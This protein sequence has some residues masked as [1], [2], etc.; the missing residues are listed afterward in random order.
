MLRNLNQV[1]SGQRICGTPKSGVLGSLIPATGESGA[2]Y[3]Y[4][5][6]T[7]PADNDKEIRGKI[8]RWPT[9]G[10]LFAFEDTSFTYDGLTDSFDYQLAVDGVEVG[11]PVTVTLLVGATTH[12]S[13]GSLVSGSAAVSGTSLRVRVHSSDGALIADFAQLVGSAA[14]SGSVIHAAIA[15]LSAGAAQIA[16]SANRVGISIHGASGDLISGAATLTASAS[17]SGS[18]VLSL[19]QDDINAIA[20]AVLAALNAT[21]IPVDLIKVKGQ[22]ITGLGTEASPWG[23]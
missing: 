19:T 21:A 22:T 4:N 20:A 3:A 15:G 17:R 5:D 9:L 7:L 10:S 18:V 1:A 11:S 12:A 14:L 2:G 13:S 23:P 6:L 8:T 16:G